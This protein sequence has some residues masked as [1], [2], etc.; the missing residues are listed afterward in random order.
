LDRIGAAT[1]AATFAV[2][3]VGALAVGWLRRRRMQ[4]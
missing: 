3:L 2:L 4:P 1:V